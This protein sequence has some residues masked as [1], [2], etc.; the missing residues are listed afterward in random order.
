VRQPDKVLANRK[1]FADQGRNFIMVAREIDITDYVLAGFKMS[2]IAPD[3]FLHRD[4]SVFLSDW[5]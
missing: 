5:A 3:R 1:M 2:P 4:R